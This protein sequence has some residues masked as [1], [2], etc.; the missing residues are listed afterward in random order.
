MRIELGELKVKNYTSIH[1]MRRKV[2]RLVSKLGEDDL[3]SARIASGISQSCKEI[4]AK[5]SSLNISICLDADQ[6]GKLNLNFKFSSSEPIKE[7]SILPDFFDHVRPQTVLGN[8]YFQE[9]FLFIPTI[10]S[11]SKDF[12]WE[13]EAI[14]QEKS[15]D[16]LMDEINATNKELKESLENLKRTRSAKERMETELNIGRDIQMSMLPLE[17]P[18]FPDRKEIDIFAALH[19]AREVGGD[20]YDFFFIDEDHFCFCIGDVSDKGVPSA[21]FMA[22]TKTLIKSRASN[23]LSTGS[24]MTHVNNEMSHDNKSSM[25]V[26]LFLCILDVKSGVVRFTNA[27]H[28]PPMLKRKNGDIELLK[29]I[30]GPVI[31][32]LE[33]IDY[34]EETIRL[35]AGDLLF[36]YTD[37]VTEARNKDEK[38]FS[39]ARLEQLFE[40]AESTTIQGLADEII[41]EVEKFAIGCP[42]A[43]D[44][45]ILLMEY[46]HSN[47]KDETLT[48]E[49]K[50]KNQLIEINRVN[51][52]FNQFAQNCGL[53]VSIKRKVNLVFDEILNNIISYAFQDTGEHHIGIVVRYQPD[54]LV[55]SI[56][57]DGIPFNLLQAEEPQTD[58]PLEER[59]IGGLGIHL[60]KNVMDDYEYKRDG[61]KNISTLYK[62]LVSEE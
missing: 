57:D 26:T 58:L 5:V 37:G 48:L 2:F 50:V 36:L 59:Q 45:T 35:Q 4:I 18:P 51:E 27:G 30:H 1:E 24:I 38:L 28:N 20:F 44:I 47:E 34:K 41:D 3:L 25:F 49:L 29:N 15:R 12:I 13:L 31:G 53:N 52:E 9:A 22:V 39:D 33:G 32:A 43:D 21:L 19:P 23:D 16:E 17:F 62:N 14:I 56:S 54:Q 11:P 61:N 8:T 60:V 10:V 6:Y 40:A 42:Q 7:T 55:I 46:L